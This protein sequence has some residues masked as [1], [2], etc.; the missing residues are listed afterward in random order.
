MGESLSH[1][2]CD[3]DTLRS[4]DEMASRES[5]TLR[6]QEPTKALREEANRAVSNLLCGVVWDADSAQQGFRGYLHDRG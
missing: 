4:L 1:T 6:H 3:S 2:P 5:L